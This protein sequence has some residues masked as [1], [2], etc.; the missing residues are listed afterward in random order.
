MIGI[1]GESAPH[2]EG[3]MPPLSLMIKP[4]SGLCNQRCAYC[5]YED[6]S[7][8]RTAKSLGR[9]DHDTLETLVR[10]A[11]AYAEDAVSF[12]FQGGEPTLAGLDF[13]RDLTALQKKYNARGLRVHNAIQTNGLTI[14]DAFAAFLSENRFLVGVSL[15]GDRETHDGLRPD[16]ACCDTYDRVMR[17]I[18][19]LERHGVEFNIL[20][21]VTRRLAERAQETFEA[22]ARFGY[23]QYIPCI[24]GF[25]GV[26]GP[27][28][29]SPVLY[30][31]FL[32]TTFDCYERAHRRGK[33]VSVRT[34]D[35]LIQLLAGYPPE[36]CGMRGVCG[37]YY[38]IEAD[39]SVYPCDFY[40]LD[41]WRLG[42]I[43]EKSFHKLAKS[44][45]GD[46]FIES[47]RY[48]D[49]ACAAC[50]WY[51][52]CRGGCRRDREPFDAGRPGPNRFCESYRMLY[53]HA[54]GRMVRL[55]ND[56]LPNMR[57]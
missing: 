10:R 2:T 54:Y 46:R 27:Y 4:V 50:P 18:A 20:T 56:L 5:F 33:P 19:A 34:F 47:S 15:D 51:P 32:K 35:N 24:D 39:G 43:R 17:G 48:R 25:D 44:E 30:G 41:E 29:L 57:Q 23:L 9:M 31:E 26:P 8:H 42:N 53:A 37:R 14:D 13:Y 38:L 49:P 16:A 6:V 28:A 3:H 12:A 40:V 45:I 21:V 55:K 52:L 36:H 7:A 22:M 1:S 11:L